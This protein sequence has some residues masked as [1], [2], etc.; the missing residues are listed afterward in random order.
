MSVTV[1]FWIINKLAINKA[2]TNSVHS[3]IISDI[4]RIYLLEVKEAEKSRDCTICPLLF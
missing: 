4:K 3:N 2:I 1:P